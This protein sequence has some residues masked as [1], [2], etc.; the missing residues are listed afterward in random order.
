MP[1]YP[2]S[3]TAGAGSLGPDPSG[4]FDWDGPDQLDYGDVSGN[5]TELGGRVSMA[6]KAGFGKAARSGGDDM[7]FNLLP[8]PD[9]PS[10]GPVLKSFR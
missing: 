7:K 10:R 4:G 2:P 8:T 6:G 5:V 3:A 1:K 9:K